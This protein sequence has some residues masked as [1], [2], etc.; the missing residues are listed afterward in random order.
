ML[1]MLAGLSGRAA[2]D[3]PGVAELSRIN[4]ALRQW[5][6]LIET[7]RPYLAIDR[8]AGQV[9]LHH[10]RAIL[11]QCPVLVD[12][13][14]ERPELRSELRRRVRRYRPSAPWATKLSGPFDWEN[15]LAE[16]AAP[17]GALYFDSGLLLYA[18]A[19]WEAAGSPALRLEAVDLRALYNACEPG[20]PLV[21]LP[22]VWDE[23]TDH[24]Q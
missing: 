22:P 2:G 15:N 12:S 19:V 1:A 5:L 17:D 7:D 8:Q 10:G 9:R 20:T 13:L 11:R 24:E 6:A 14:G 18:A 4:E 16:E 21:V 23:E 3:G